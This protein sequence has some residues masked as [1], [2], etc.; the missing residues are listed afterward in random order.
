MLVG[1]REVRV[2]L[3]CDL[4]LNFEQMFFYANTSMR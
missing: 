2:V 3:F 4:Q 1:V